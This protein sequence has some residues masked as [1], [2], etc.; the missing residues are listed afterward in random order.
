M[1]YDFQLAGSPLASGRGAE[2]I[3]IAANGVSSAD[4]PLSLAYTEL[5]NIYKAAKDQDELPYDFAGTVHVTTPIGDI[6]IP[7]K[8]SGKLPVLRP[9][10][11]LPTESTGTQ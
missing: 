8:T 10:G 6:P 5:A 2:G 7:F 9:P 11:R 3:S 1:D 4:F